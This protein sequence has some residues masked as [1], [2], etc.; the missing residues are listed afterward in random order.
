[1]AAA[2]SRK[3]RKYGLADASS[4]MCWSRPSTPTIATQC[5]QILTGYFRASVGVV[6]MVSRRVPSLIKSI[7]LVVPLLM[8]GATVRAPANSLHADDCLAAPNSPAPEGSWWYYRLD[9]PTQRK[10]WYLRAP[11]RSLR[12]GTATAATPLR[13]TRARFGHRHSTD[14]LPISVDP[15]DTG[16]PSSRLL[17]VKTPTSEAIAGTV[18]KLVRQSAQQGTAPPPTETLA[19]QATPWSQAGNEPPGRP[20]EPTTG[21]D[22]VPAGA[23]VEALLVNSNTTNTAADSASDVAERAAGGSKLTNDAG[24]SMVTILAVLA[25]GLGVLCVVAKNVAMRWVRTIVNH[26]E[27]N[28]T[29][30]QHRHDR[31]GD[32]DQRGSVDERQLIVSVL[33]DHSPIQNDD[34]PFQTA[35]EISK[36]KDKLA[37]L[38]QNLDRLLQSPTMA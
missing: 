8:L 25:L 38:H 2:Q 36:R 9:W 33:S 26:R 6:G 28:S 24:I 3:T 1:M 37:R 12:R 27:A 13:S 14:G 17:S 15:S 16:L 32:Q 35:V 20:V 18:D 34:I 11:D 4:A 7:T 30:E 19:S 31:R 21:P 29:D 5:D 10:C 22:P 23:A